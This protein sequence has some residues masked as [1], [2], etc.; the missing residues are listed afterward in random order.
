MH[1]QVSPLDLECLVN[2]A[3]A[4]VVVVVSRLTRLPLPSPLCLSLS[5]PQL[6]AAPRRFSLGADASSCVSPLSPVMVEER[7]ERLYLDA[8]TRE[9][10]RANAVKQL[11]EEVQRAGRPAI[12]PRGQQVKGT[13]KGSDRLYEEARKMGERKAKLVR[14]HGDTQRQG[15]GRAGGGRRAGLVWGVRGVEGVR[16]SVCC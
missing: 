13:K 10:K 3:C 8:Q 11:Q 4:V 9:A 2:L 5:R 12:T 16:W 1:L 6:I 7:F 15:Q 14:R